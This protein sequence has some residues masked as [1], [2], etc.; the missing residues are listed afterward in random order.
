MLFH[1]SGDAQIG[2]HANSGLWRPSADS[3]RISV[4]LYQ[5]ELKGSGQLQLPEE[6][7]DSIV[8]V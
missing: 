3:H 1:R 6:L 5:T 8:G 4:V 7:P 2:V